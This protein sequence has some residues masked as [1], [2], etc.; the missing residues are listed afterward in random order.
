MKRLWAIALIALVACGSDPAPS[1]PAIPQQKL[2]TMSAKPVIKKITLP[3]NVSRSFL[4]YELTNSTDSQ[5]RIEHIDAE[6]SDSVRI[7]KT[8]LVNFSLHAPKMLGFRAELPPAQQINGKC[9]VLKTRPAKS[10][11]VKPH[12]SVYLLLWIKSKKPG[13][14][15]LGPFDVFYQQGEDSFREVADLRLKVTVKRGAKP[16]SIKEAERLCLT[17]KGVKLVFER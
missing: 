9:R 1:D 5:V 15:T 11:F 14:A 16:P 2:L 13:R 8:K 7:V 10:A 4:G 6:S 3:P 12:S 17:A